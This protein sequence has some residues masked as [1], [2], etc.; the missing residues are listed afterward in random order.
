MY[1]AQGVRDEQTECFDKQII[2]T[3]IHRYQ[4]RFKHEINLN[5][6]MNNA[7]NF[8]VLKVFSMFMLII[9]DVKTSMHSHFTTK[10]L[11]L[12]C[13]NGLHCKW[14]NILFSYLYLFFVY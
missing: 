8:S 9:Q 3:D 5:A 12:R 10:S 14:N 2:D 13:V 7:Y 4:T 11:F 6:P 1:P